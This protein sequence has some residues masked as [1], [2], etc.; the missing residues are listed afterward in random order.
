[1]AE[2]VAGLLISKQRQQIATCLPLYRSFSVHVVVKS[3]WPRRQD[4]QRR[5]A[6]IT[7]VVGSN[8]TLGSSFFAFRPEIGNATADFRPLKSP[9]NAR[10]K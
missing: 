1:M 6:D 10:A 8:P 2:N 9:A 4:A 5:C 7:E 3:A